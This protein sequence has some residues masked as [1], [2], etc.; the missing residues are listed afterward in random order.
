LH[1][2]FTPEGSPILVFEG[3]Y[4]GDFADRPARTPRYDYNQMLYRL[5]LDDPAL[6]PAQRSATK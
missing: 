6:R 2:K 3:T 5:D 4:T 1:S